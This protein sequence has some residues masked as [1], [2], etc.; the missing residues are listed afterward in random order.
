M[1]AGLTIGTVPYLNARPLVRWFTDTEEGRASGIRVVEA[2]PTRLAVM[3][4][5][6]EVAAALISSFEL[7]R[8]PG[9]RYAPGVA[10]AAD[11]P[12]LSV[13]LLSKAPIPQ[14]QSVALDTSS[15]TSVALLKIL[16]AEQFG[17]Q[18]RFVPAAPDLPAMLARCDACL[19]IGDAGYRHYDASLH[20]LDL[21]AGWKTLTGLPFAYALW[22]GT[23]ESLTPD[24]CATLLKARKWGTAHLEE[25]ARAEYAPLGE[26][27]ARTHDYLTRI[28]RY[29]LDEAG[30]QALRLFGEKAF[31]RGLL[32]A[33]PLVEATCR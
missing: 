29:D 18:P 26:T 21:G 16:L 14:I 11:G 10:V 4:E 17:L 5:Q 25:I 32:S 31:R 19:L 13:R 27:Y 6:G 3:R 24:L 8:R 33:P 7:F 15:L 22:I 23:P 28:M 1:S 20:V 12:V 30:E 2:V 9:L